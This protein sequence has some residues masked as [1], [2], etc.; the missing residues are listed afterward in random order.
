L[1]NLTFSQQ[2]AE[3]FSGRWSHCRRIQKILAQK[4]TI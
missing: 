3:M 1:M 2:G 4:Q